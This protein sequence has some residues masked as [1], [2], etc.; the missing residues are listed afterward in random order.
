[1]SAR[2]TQCQHL[3]KA[4]QQMNVQLHHVLSDVT[5]IS[6]LAI[7]QGILEG[8]RDPIKLAAMVDR[9]VRA[10]QGVIQ[11][12]LVGDYR[13]EHLFVLKSA[14]ELYQRVLRKP[15]REVLISLGILR[16]SISVE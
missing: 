9:R 13:T 15:K 3:Q 11:K 1:M 6:G 2:S 7:I 16:V 14:F 8:Q 12:A 5:G 10:R 4:L